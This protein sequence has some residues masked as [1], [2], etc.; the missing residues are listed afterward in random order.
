MQQKK[1]RKRVAITAALIAC[2]VAVAGL[3]TLA[4]LTAQD[5]VDNVFMT[6]NFGNTDKEPNPDNPDTSI[7]EDENPS[8]EDNTSNSYLFETKWEEGSKLQQGAVIA[9]NPNVGMTSTSD[10][11]YVFLYVKSDVF[12]ADALKE[13]VDASATIDSY[14]PGNA[15]YF[16]LEHQWAPVT[17]HGDQQ[18][19]KSTADSDAYISGLFTYVGDN[20][21]GSGNPFIFQGSASAGGTATDIFTG[22]LFEEVTVPEGV[23]MR[24][25]KS[26]TG[27]T[28][29]GDL[30]GPTITVYAY[31]YGADS[32]AIE[33]DEGSQ[34]AAIKD[35]IDWAEKLG[36]Q[37]ITE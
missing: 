23:D 26:V 22:E 21:A 30:R 16:T 28:A 18:V 37:E 1:N 36:W 29:S 32:T 31:L 35:A 12:D 27:S 11:A 15:P 24:V 17:D 9:K 25:F 3:G 19:I 14:A 34:T 8:N 2:L 13:Y 6:G 33:G 7:D 10:P 4:W 5:Q 20:N